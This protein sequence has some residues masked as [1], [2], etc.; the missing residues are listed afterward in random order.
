MKV[1][2]LIFIFTSPLFFRICNGQVKSDTTQSPGSKKQLDSNYVQT[3]PQFLTLG[4]FN[5]TPVMQ[6]RF[7]PVDDNLGKYSSDFR[8]NFSDIQGILLAY[9]SI[10]IRVGFRTPVGPKSDDTKGRSAHTSLLIKIKKPNIF[11]IAEYRR[12]NGY[13][14][15]DASPDSV[16]YVRPDLRYKNIGVN[17]VYNFSWKKYSYLAPITFT[18]RQIKSRIGFLAKGGLNY[19]TISSSNAS[20]LPEQNTVHFPAYDDI[21]SVNAI[22]LKA[23]PGAGLNVVIL[24]R[25]YFAFNYFIMGNYIAYTYVHRTK[26]VSRW[27]DNTN[28]YTESAMSFG[29][30]SKRLFFGLTG[31]GDINVMRI[32]QASLMTNFASASLTLGYRFNAPEFLSKGWDKT[33][34]RLK[35]VKG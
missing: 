5:A 34:K 15:N 18:D 27:R 22:L 10:A 3:Y 17:G 9:R 2:L 24:K 19:T 31:S 8:G 35:K 26:G 14:D 32:K 28:F 23:G 7:T 29:Y 13:Y 25:L 16:Y 6:M 20:I 21:Q 11:M 30:N 12:Y 1:I 33:T 4:I